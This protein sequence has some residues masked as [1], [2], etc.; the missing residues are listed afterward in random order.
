MMLLM[1]RLQS[2]LGNMRVNL[3]GGKIGV[4]EEHLHHPQ[5]GAVVEQVRGESMAQG[6][7]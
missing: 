1:E 4:A 2:R 3:R 6:V 5:I 7:R